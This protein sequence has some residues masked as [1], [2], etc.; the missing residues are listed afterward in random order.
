MQALLPR[1]DKSEAITLFL[2]KSRC[3][4]EAGGQG[5]VR[6]KS[7]VADTPEAAHGIDAVSIGT[8]TLNLAFIDIDTASGIQPLIALRTFN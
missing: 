2:A 5:G 4:G 6:H 3:F 8:N 1:T 7:W